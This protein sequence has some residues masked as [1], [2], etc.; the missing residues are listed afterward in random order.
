M[1]A[2]RDSMIMTGSAALPIAYDELELLLR[3]C[4]LRRPPAKLDMSIK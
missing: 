2:K 1:P 3:I 4:L